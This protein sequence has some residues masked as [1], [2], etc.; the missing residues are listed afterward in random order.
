MSGDHDGRPV[1]RQA[2]I[3]GAVQDLMEFAVDIARDAGRVILGHYRD[4]SLAVDHKA[5][6]SPVT[7]AD[8]AAETLLRQRITA[9]FPDDAIVGEEH[10]DVLTGVARPAAHGVQHDDAPSLCQTSS[11][12]QFWRRFWLNSRRTWPLGH[13]TS[14]A[15]SATLLPISWSS[16]V[17]SWRSRPRRQYM[18]HS[19]PRDP[20]HLG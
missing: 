15:S 19:G 3:V 20:L 4:S 10:D 14:S 5:D 7:V 12:M 6:D 8:R 18:H 13:R 11:G 17:T 16:Y 9:A 1:V 2:S